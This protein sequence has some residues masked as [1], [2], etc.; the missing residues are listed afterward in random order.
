MSNYKQNKDEL[1]NKFTAGLLTVGEYRRLED[2][3]TK[4]MEDELVCN[5]ISIMRIVIMMTTNTDVFN[6]YH[7]CL[8]IQFICYYDSDIHCNEK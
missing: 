2:E 4:R 5:L 6:M 1:V 8:C 3:L 7:C